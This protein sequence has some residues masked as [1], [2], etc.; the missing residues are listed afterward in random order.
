M[1]TEITQGQVNGFRM[2]RHFL[3]T[4]ASVKNLES[5]VIRVCGI[6]AQMPAPA[7]LQLWARTER[8]KPKDVTEALWNSRSL[9]RTWCM[10][11]TAHYIA[12]K[13]F[14]TYLKAILEPRIPRH[15]EWLTKRGMREFG[16]IVK[17]DPI[18]HDFEAILTAVLHAL[19]NGPATRDEVAKIVAEEVGPEARPWVD[20]GYYIVTKLLAYEGRICFGPDLEGKTS[21]VLTD[22]WL[23]PQPLLQK[24]IAEDRVLRNYLGCYGPATPQDFSA[25]SGLKMAT[26]K[27][28][29]ER[30]LTHLTEVTL[31]EKPLWILQTDLDALL[32]TQTDARPVRLLPNFDIF[33][34]GHKDKSHIVDEA[35]YKQVFKKAAWI[36]PV[37]LCDGQA[38]GTW[39][40][41]RTTQKVTITLEPFKT[42][43]KSQ[44]NDVE[45]EAHRLGDY[46]E[47]TPE[48]QL[49]K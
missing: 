28:I 29:W 38:I 34:L 48:V 6:Q 44:H 17:I 24:E 41:K 27:P 2:D 19:S 12:S 8:L 30:N 31:N 14:P 3:T 37:I 36:A 43:T 18:Q 22:Q 46:F 23:P 10:R 42:L 7:S 26:I 16:E 13:E 39:T 40:Q 32:A 20:T 1:I 33:L 5:M 47:L 4:R 49:R 21:L 45:T 25:W 15:K 11:G 9:L 35:H